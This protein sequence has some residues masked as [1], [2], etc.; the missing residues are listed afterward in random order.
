MRPARRA[1]RAGGRS[2]AASIGLLPPTAASAPSPASA[3]SMTSVRE[4]RKRRGALGQAGRGDDVRRARRRARGRR[5]SSG[6]TSA[7]RSATGASSSPAPQ[8]TKRSTPRG[9]S[10]LRQRRR[11]VA[12]DD[13]AFGQRAH[14]LLDG[15]GQ[16]RVERPRDRPAAAARA[17]RARGGGPQPS[18][19]GASATTASGASGRVHHRD[20]IGV[21]QRAL[22]SAELRGPRPAATA[23]G[24]PRPRPGRPQS[25]R[26][27]S[28]CQRTLSVN[29][30][31]T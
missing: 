12:A 2:A 18:T 4:P 6:A 10:P 17:H 20:G 26:L 28:S 16:R 3:G 11:V 27:A 9:G 23:T 14:L 31:F 24:R 1:A 25:L 13:G 29:V 8:I 15:D 30:S 21:R 19:P 22:R 5:W 7:A